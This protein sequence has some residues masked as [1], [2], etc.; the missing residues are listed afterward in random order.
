MAFFALAVGIIYLPRLCTICFCGEIVILTISASAPGSE[1]HS[2]LST[3]T[4][5]YL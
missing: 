1:S 5:L 2:F 4:A 3:I